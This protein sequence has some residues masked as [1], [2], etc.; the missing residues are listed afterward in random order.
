M[1]DTLRM[2]HER[3]GV[4]VTTHPEMTDIGTIGLGTENIG[5]IDPESEMTRGG[6]TTTGET[7]DPAGITI[8][9]G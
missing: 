8:G 2:D 1:T 9:E 6:T 3:A 4:T 7:T 5:G